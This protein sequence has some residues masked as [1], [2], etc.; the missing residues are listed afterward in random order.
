VNAVRMEMMQVR[1]RDKAECNAWK[2]KHEVLLAGHANL[3]RQTYQSTL[4]C[5]QTFSK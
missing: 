4:C 1:D 2:V 3:V 5:S